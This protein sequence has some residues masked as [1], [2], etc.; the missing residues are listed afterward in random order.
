MT[1][2]SQFLYF[3][4]ARPEGYKKDEY[5]V[6]IGTSNNVKETRTLLEDAGWSDL[7]TYAVFQGSIVEK[8]LAIAHEKFAGSSLKRGWFR[9]KKPELDS[10][11]ETLAVEPGIKYTQE[12]K[13][14]IGKRVAKKKEG[15]EEGTPVERSVT[16]HVE[17]PAERPVEK[18][19]ERPVS[20]HVEKQVEKSADKSTE[21]PAEKP[22]S[23]PAERPTDKSAERSGDRARKPR[24]LAASDNFDHSSLDWN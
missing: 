24:A 12:S 16:R 2:A 5:A 14:K 3:I 23:R 22:V 18:S 9:V 19:A 15:G 1:D 17:T 21:R 13:A 7:R 8:L 10:Y 20:R 11:L 4:V 6:K